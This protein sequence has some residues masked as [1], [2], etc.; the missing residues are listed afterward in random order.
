MLEK[1]ADWD[2]L[3]TWHWEEQMTGSWRKLHN[4]ELH[5]LYSSC[6]INSVIKSRWLRWAEHVAH[7]CRWQMHTQ[8]WLGSLKGRD[9]WEVVGKDGRIILNYILRKY[10]MEWNYVAQNNDWWRALVNKV[11]NSNIPSK[12]GNFLTSWD[13]ELLKKDC[14]PWS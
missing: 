14:A 10:D 9:H 3:R 8:F 4:E 5:N 12:A 7:T 2:C 13:Y 6:I 1:N 11:M